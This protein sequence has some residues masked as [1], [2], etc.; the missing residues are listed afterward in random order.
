MD[1]T[2]KI[3]ALIT[4]AIAAILFSGCSFKLEA[5]YHGKTGIDDRVQT[6]LV[7]SEQYYEETEKRRK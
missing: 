1:A 6:S 2:C 7:G 5:G 4:S 3:I